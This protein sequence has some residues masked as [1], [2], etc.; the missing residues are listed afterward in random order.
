MNI[1]EACAHFQGAEQFSEKLG[2]KKKKETDFIFLPFLCP[3]KEALP[4]FP[5]AVSLLETFDFT[6]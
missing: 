3:K 1:F 4:N 5:N 2:V 6:G